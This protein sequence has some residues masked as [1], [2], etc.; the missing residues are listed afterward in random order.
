MSSTNWNSLPPPRS[1]TCIRPCILFHTSYTTH[2]ILFH[3]SY[4]T[5]DI[6]FHTSY[7]TH[8]ILFHTSYTTHDILFHTSYTTHDNIL[9]YA[10]RFERTPELLSRGRSKRSAELHDEDDDYFNSEFAYDETFKG[11]VGALSFFFL[12]FFFM[13]VLPVSLCSA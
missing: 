8:D 9:F 5:H 2:D 13:Y 3:T 7:T 11:Q 10:S 6:L 1:R 4:T 12:F